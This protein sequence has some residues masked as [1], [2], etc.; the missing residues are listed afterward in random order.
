MFNRLVIRKA[1]MKDLDQ[2]E[3][4][5]KMAYSGLTS[6]P[7]DRRMLERRLNQSE[8]SFEKKV[9]TTPNNELYLFVMEDVVLSKVVGICG[10][11]GSIGCDDL[12]Y[13][14]NLQKIKKESWTLNSEKELEILRLERTMNGPSEIGTLF[15]RPEYRQ[16]NVGRFLS[17]SRFLFMAE[18]QDRF[19]KQVIAEMRGVIDQDGRCPFWDHVGTHFFDMDFEQADILSAEDK[20]FIAELMPKYPIYVNLLPDKIKNIIGK[21]HKHTLPALKI[22]Q[23]EGF[24][25]TN[26]VDIFDGGPK[27]VAEVNQLRTVANSRLAKVKSFSKQDIRSKLFLV[28]HGELKDFRVCCTHL[29]QESHN[30]VIIPNHLDRLECSPKETVRYITLEPIER[31]N[32][33]RRHSLEKLS[34]SMELNVKLSSSYL[35]DNKST[36]VSFLR[37][38]SDWYKTTSITKDKTQSK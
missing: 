13:T 11:V 5:A 9:I 32:Q 37:R 24:R 2:I 33:Y 30:E 26:S 19:K 6:L 21:A 27:I 18:H 22:L 34:G 7:K 23:R 1:N 8:R 16:K 20:S 4:L 28:S 38:F 12:F 15:L 3:E 29:E 17:L 14:Y 31:E 35:E 25:L 10:I 36:S